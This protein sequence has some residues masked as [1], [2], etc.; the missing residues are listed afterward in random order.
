[1][2]FGVEVTGF[3]SYASPAVV[4]EIAGCA[5]AVGWD[6]LFIWDHLA[7]AGGIPSGDPWISLA[8]AACATTRISLG[9]DVSPLPRRRPQIVATAVA[10]L[11]QL[12]NG[13]TI[14]GAGLGGSEAEYTVFGE[15]PDARVRAG[16]LDESLDILD[17]LWR[18][19]RVDHHGP[20]YTVSGATLAPLP[21]QRPR[22]PIWIGGAAA[23]A[24]RRA[25]RWD[26]YAVGAIVDEHGVVTIGPEE[27][28]LLDR[29]RAGP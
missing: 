20:N 12:S 15:E 5:E 16:K 4:A 24:L 17:Q 27:V 7:W 23:P 18:G 28:R 14:F 19:H 21:I 6:G 29:V 13:R 3:G 22:P 8:A 11:D 9:L 1:M 25:A 10:A 2:R 26:G